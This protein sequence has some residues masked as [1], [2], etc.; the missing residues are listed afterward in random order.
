MTELEAI[1]Q[2]MKDAYALLAEALYDITAYKVSHPERSPVETWQKEQGAPIAEEPEPL[3]INDEWRAALHELHYAY[4]NIFLTG[5]AGTG[6]STLLQKFATEFNGNLAIVAPTGVAALRVK[7]TTIHRFFKFGAHALEESDIPELEDSRK[8]KYKALKVLV[9]DEISM[10]RA[11]LMDAIDIFLR[12]NGPDETQAFG[13][14]RIIMF[15]DLFQL[16]PISRDKNEKAWL[17]SKYGTETPYFFHAA[18]WRETQL[19][20]IELTT[21]FRQKDAVFTDALNKV[22][23]GTDTQSALRVINAR[24]GAPTRAEWLTLTT[25]NEAAD[26]ANQAMLKAIR[27]PGETFD[28]IVVGDFDLKDAPTDV[29]L[30]LKVGAKVMF[31]R[32]DAEHQWVNGTLGEVAVLDPLSITLTNGHRVSVYPEDWEKID[33]QYDKSSHKL[34]RKVTGGFT[35]IPLKLAAAITIHK[36]QGMTFDRCVI[37][38]GYG[39]FAAGQA[40][41]ALSRCRTLEGLYLRHPVTEKDLIVSTE[42]QAFMTGQ[43]IKSSSYNLSLGLE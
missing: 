34:T 37:D 39:A 3:T 27:T 30:E 35:Q 4:N 7:G 5:E 8:A 25:T 16:P 13:G 36:S 32:N 42:V 33:Y 2:K 14:V 41:V 20:L 38:L 29:H 23:R 12:K 1:E 24:A 31:I 18:V 28:A 6:K 10:V 40:Y 9:I 17:K 19:K 11:D 21:I 22:R 15:G 26:R 43:P